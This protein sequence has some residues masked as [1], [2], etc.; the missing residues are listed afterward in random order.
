[1]VL[2]SDLVKF[3]QGYPDQDLPAGSTVTDILEG[4]GLL[5][6][7]LKPATSPAQRIPTT[8]VPPGFTPAD[9]LLQA[10][11][12]NKAVP[13]SDADMANAAMP[14]TWIASAAA[15]AALDWNG[16]ACSQNNVKPG[17]TVNPFAT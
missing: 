1:M 2:I 7:G 15:K 16:Y 6:T 12:A 8:V 17:S 9:Q 10:L 4:K 11:A 5:K 3:L 14:S 13:M